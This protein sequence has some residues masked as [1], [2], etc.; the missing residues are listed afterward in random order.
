MNPVLILT[1]NNLEL[2]KKC[3]ES[4]R[5]QDVD[6]VT[7]R[8]LDNA[9]TDK[10]VPWFHE[11]W[12]SGYHEWSFF[13]FE[14]NK[15][16]SYGWNYG[17]REFFDNNN[18]DHVLVLNNDV[19]IPPWF[20]RFLLSYTMPSFVTG[21]S[22]DTMEQIATPPGKTELVPFPDFSAFLIHREAWNIVGFFDERMK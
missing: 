10:T 17:L 19:I 5:A 14:S 16:V 3:V 21:I 18:A 1:H 4:V 22:I 12:K 11:L 7:L 8:I 6:D 15:G 20:Y 9:S 2:T 13:N